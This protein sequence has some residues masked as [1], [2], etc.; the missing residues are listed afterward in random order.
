MAYVTFLV[1]PILGLYKLARLRSERAGYAAI[2]ILIVAS[3]IFTATTSLM[4]AARR[5]EVFGVSAAYCAVL[6]VFIGSTTQT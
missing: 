1:V 5:H 6:V 2:G 3:L 4:T